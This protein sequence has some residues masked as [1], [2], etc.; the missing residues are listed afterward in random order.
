MADAALVETEMSAGRELVMAL[1]AASFPAFAALWLLRPESDEWRF[2]IGSPLVD[3]EG[4]HAAYSRLQTIL[5]EA[6]V[7]LPLRVVTL[8][9]TT[10]P[11]LQL[12]MTAVA[13]EGISQ[14]RFQNNTISGVLIPDAVI[15]R[16]RRPG[17]LPGPAG[18]EPPSAA[19]T[20]PAATKR[21]NA[22]KARSTRK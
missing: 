11:L 9:G 8:V 13:V 14:I 17:T 1:D 4:R 3:V 18:M 20:K 5:E 22:P 7:H 16:L 2:Y 12:L 19:R 15:Y 21:T 10:D 6:D